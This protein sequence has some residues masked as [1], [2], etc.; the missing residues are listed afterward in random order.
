ML[1]TS[2]RL[3]LVSFEKFRS[4]IY[5]SKG[6]EKYVYFYVLDPDSVLNGEPRLKRI[7]KKFNHIKTKKERDEAALRFRDEI[8]VKL[9]QGW[10][11]LIQECGKKGFTLFTTVIDRYV[12][13]LKKMLKDDVV[14][15]STFNNYMCRLNQLK[16][17]NE[18]LGTPIIYIYQFDR[19]ALE[20]F[21]EHIYID[22]DT[23]PKTRNNYLNWLSSICSWMKGCGY[24]ETNPAESISKLR[25]QEKFRKAL[26]EADM[27]KLHDYLSEHDK[28]FLLACLMHYYTLVRPNEL[29]YIRIEDIRIRDQTLFISHEFSKNRKDAVVTVPK[30]VLQ[31]M[32]VLDV[33]SH[34]DSFYLFG[35]DF[36]PSEHRADGRIFRERWIKVREALDFPSH[37]QFYSLKDTGITDA[38]DRVG[39]TVAKDQARHSSVATTNRYVRKGQLKAHPELKDFEGNF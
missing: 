33:F 26:D 37:Y 17:W 16:E 38:I 5:V 31:M 23:T 30:R 29:A 15:Q 19:P 13:Y 18:S 4:P 8:A 39:L 22:R 9:K 25:E 10:N 21:L 2:K 11:P 7:R 12:T 20:G 3:N 1:P 35:R 24:I 34:P 27:K 6:K 28:H 32:L 36:K 14:K